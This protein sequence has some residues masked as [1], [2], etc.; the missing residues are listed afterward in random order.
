MSSENKT[1]SVVESLCGGDAK[2]LAQSVRES[3]ELLHGSDFENNGIAEAGFK[4]AV[5]MSI[6]PHLGKS[7][8]MKSE[9]IV[10]KGKSDQVKRGCAAKGLCPFPKPRFVC[11][12]I[13]DGLLITRQNCVFGSNSHQ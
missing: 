7:D 1:K 9:V 4:L 11:L 3:L 12:C 10:R 13:C 8:D 2:S 6:K 5:M